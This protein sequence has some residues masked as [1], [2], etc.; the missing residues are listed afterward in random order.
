MLNTGPALKVTI[1]MNDDTGSET[2]FLHQDLL[3]LL[4]ERG[5]EG[6]SVLRPYAGYGAHGMLHVAGAGP[7]EGEHMPIL[8]SF[9]DSVEKIE[10]LLP[11]LLEAVTDGL[12]EAHPTQIL[13]SVLRRS[14]VVS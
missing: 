2:A 1:Y 6:V 12:V 9:V 5:I 13:K 11:E 7:V 4:R 10:A 14:K 3:A 8:L